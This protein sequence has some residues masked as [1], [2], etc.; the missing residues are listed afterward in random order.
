MAAFM[1][2]L[3]SRTFDA[4]ILAKSPQV[5]S[6]DRAYYTQSQKAEGR[7]QSKSGKRGPLLV[8]IAKAPVQAY[9]RKR[10]ENSAKALIPLV[11]ARRHQ[12][13]PG[14]IEQAGKEHGIHL[15]FL[16]RLH[17]GFSIYPETLRVAPAGVYPQHPAQ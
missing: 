1:R 5:D 16:A 13:P 6:G 2:W 11:S 3:P 12:L 8:S 15:H 9:E 7:R 17:L 10:C 14:Q 4:S